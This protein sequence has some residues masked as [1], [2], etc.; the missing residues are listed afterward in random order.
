[1]KTDFLANISHELRTP[2]NSILGYT[3]LL[4]D[5]VDGPLNVEQK[6]SLQ[7]VEKASRRLLQ[8]I[9]DVL[10]LSKLRAGKIELNLEIVSLHDI[11]ADALNIIEPLARNKEVEVKVEENELP[12]LLVDRDKIIQVLLNLLSNAVKFTG[13]QGLITVSTYL[14]TLPEAPGVVK[15]YAAIQVKDTGI[16]IK[17]G[18]LKNIFQEFVQINSSATRLASGTGLGLPI[19][20]RLVELHKGRLWVESEYGRGSIFTF[21]L[22]LEP[23]SPISPAGIEKAV[24]PGRLVLGITR[25]SGLIELLHKT[26][27]PLGFTFQS[28][29]MVDNILEKIQIVSPAVIVVDFLD[30]LGQPLEDFRRLRAG[31]RSRDLPLLPLALSEDGRSGIVLGPME[32]LNQPSVPEEFNRSLKNLSSWIVYKEALIIDQDQEGCSL[33]VTLLKEEGFETTSA[34]NGEEAIRQ[35]ENV[36]PGLVVINLSLKAAEVARVLEFV[37]SQTETLIVP[38][39]C[40]LPRHLEVHEQHELQEQLRRSLNPKKFP[41]ANFEQNLKRFFSQVAAGSLE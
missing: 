4:L 18:D 2:L 6:S 15:D 37:R 22:P 30:R 27:T 10:D 38:L 35:L 36:L 29:A 11:V 7:R 40:L 3:E 28:V 21:I 39:L 31:S 14:Q 24:F 16:G 20:R 34:E 23:S 33:W 13:P 1:M 25:R 8:L 12:L 9:N 5:G 32:F 26:I 41:L 19:S 17:E